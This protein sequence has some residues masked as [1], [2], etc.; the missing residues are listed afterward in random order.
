MGGP[1]P[2]Q[3]QLGLL[4]QVRG[5]MMYTVPAVADTST[6]EGWASGPLPALSAT[7]P[8]QAA[9]TLITSPQEDCR[10]SYHREKPRWGESW[11]AY[12]GAETLYLFHPRQLGTLCVSQ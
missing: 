1:V 3:G 5:S 10:E 4:G 2:F 9:L 12:P 8:A 11:G 6:W 7:L